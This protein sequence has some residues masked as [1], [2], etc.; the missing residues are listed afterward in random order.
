MNIFA[1]VV[2]V[3]DALRPPAYCAFVACGGGEIVSV[4]AYLPARLDTMPRSE[5]YSPSR[6]AC[7]TAGYCRP[8]LRTALA[9]LRFFHLPHYR[10]RAR[11]LL[12]TAAAYNPHYPPGGGLV[13]V[14]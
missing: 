7:A 14:T 10:A 9:L 5:L 3:G 11:H 6:R 8:L 4:A 12:L 13:R 1:V 2:F